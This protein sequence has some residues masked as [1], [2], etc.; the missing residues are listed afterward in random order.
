MASASRNLKFV[1]LN[2]K[3]QELPSQ[4][5]EPVDFDDKAS[6]CANF[7]LKVYHKQNNVDK[8]A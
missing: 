2:N 1:T 6:Y 4:N 3:K 5:A 7:I 8:D